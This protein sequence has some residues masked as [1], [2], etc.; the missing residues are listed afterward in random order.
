MKNQKEGKP[1]ENDLAILRKLSILAGG[2]AQP[3]RLLDRLQEVTQTDKHLN[4]PS[5][6]LLKIL[7]PATCHRKFIWSFVL[8][9]PPVQSTK[10]SE[11]PSL[12]P[13]AEHRDERQVAL[14]VNRSFVYY[15]KHV[16][17]HVKTH[18][19]ETLS[20]IIIT[21]LRRFPKLN[22]FQGYHDI[23]SIFLLNFLDLETLSIISE[24]E[25]EEEQKGKDKLEVRPIEKNDYDRHKLADRT[26]IDQDLRLLEETVQKFTL[27]R[28]RDSMTSDLSPIM[29]YLRF[30]QAIL[31][32]EK[33]RFASLI[34]QTSSLP[35]FSL[36]WIL[37]LTSHD[38]TSLDVVSRIFDL[39]LCHPPVMICY[40]ACAICL[41]KMD[42]VDRLVADALADGSELDID[43]VHFVM[44]SLPP[45][46][47]DPPEQTM[48]TKPDSHSA[49]GH[50]KNNPTIKEDGS[51]PTNLAAQQR[52][53]NN[54]PLI[55]QL[56]QDQPGAETETAQ[57]DGDERG[58]K[59]EQTTQP[60][61]EARRKAGVSIEAIVQSALRLYTTHGP[62]DGHLKLHKIMGPKSCI[63]TW[64]Q[65]QAHQ[66]SDQEA[67]EII[68][69]PLHL[70]VRPAPAPKQRKTLMLARRNLKLSFNKLKVRVQKLFSKNPHRHRLVL[71]TT[72]CLVAYIAV[73]YYATA[74]SFSSSP[75]VSLLH[76]Y[77]PE[78]TSLLGHVF[79]DL[80]QRLAALF[81]Q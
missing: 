34:S 19:R 48:V 4:P 62:S 56:P 58:I 55:D 9:I 39:L 69:L 66:L 42:E 30:T 45:L 2:F 63:H 22:Y 59:Q 67:E 7:H 77:M 79:L 11:S 38:L 32:R 15:P 12:E 41:T 71:L 17:D 64:S 20:H 6:Q 1:S 35:L 51:A 27:H 75:L 43:M 23:V 25:E 44:S 46:T 50:E 5:T 29:G 40:L 21:I 28:I 73:R 78:H 33:P 10:N 70:I 16:P 61:E 54:P 37:T 60:D 47:M 57:I 31:K 18:L 36:S 49:A 80:Q 3:H 72:S 74:P 14:D 13:K 52:S 68:D 26:N 81:V 76:Q 53:Q 65:S 24:E 8:G